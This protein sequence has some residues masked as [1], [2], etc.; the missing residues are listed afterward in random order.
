MLQATKITKGSINYAIATPTSDCKIC[1]S[2]LKIRI[3]IFAH[4][5]PTAS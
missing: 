5:L 4:T 2:P 1:N 3:F